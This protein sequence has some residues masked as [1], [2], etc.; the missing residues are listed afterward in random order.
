[1]PDRN[2]T[3]RQIQVNTRSG[4]VLVG[5]VHGAEDAPVV[6][7]LHGYPDTRLVWQ[8]VADVLATTRCVVCFDVRGAG[9]SFKPHG[10]S[11]Y[12]LPKLAED[13]GTVI[14][15]VSPHRPVH[16]VGHDWGGIQAWEAAAD[17]ALSRRISSLTTIS[18]PCLDHVGHWLRRHS[19]RHPAAALRQLLGSW[20]IGALHVP[21][22]PTLAWSL[23]LGSH[24]PQL[25]ARQEG[26]PAD[27]DPTQQKTGR[28]GAAMYRANMIPRLL[29]PR[30]RTVEVPVQTI[31]PTRDRYVSEALA[32]TAESWVT[33]RRR[34]AVDAGHWLPLTHPD[35]LAARIEEFTAQVEAAHAPTTKAHTGSDRAIPAGPRLFH[36]TEAAS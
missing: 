17:A 28:H 7:L 31:V 22:V 12:T 27:A 5:D 29:R 13:I 2:R 15:Q 8:Q 1:M 25:V 30:R 10:T 4:G 19:Y 3:M 16:L 14:E 21:A 36:P 6:V 34:V 18:G 11:A 32:D 9:D 33:H 24:W 23:G 26:A 35:W 20:Y